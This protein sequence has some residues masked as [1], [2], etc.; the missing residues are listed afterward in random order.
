MEDKKV[1]DIPERDATR[2][3]DFLNNVRTAQEIVETVK[4]N[5]NKEIEMKIAENIIEARKE[6][7]G[8]KYLSQIYKIKDMKSEIFA[9]I[10]GGL[11]DW[12]PQKPNEIEWEKVP[13]EIAPTIMMFR[14]S[15]NAVLLSSLNLTP[16]TM[17]SK[18]GLETSMPCGE[19]VTFCTTQNV[20][21]HFYGMDH[22]D[23]ARYIGFLVNLGVPRDI[24]EK[25]IYNL[26]DSFSDQARELAELEAKQQVIDALMGQ[27][28]SLNCPDDCPMVIDEIAIKDEPDIPPWIHRS[29]HD[30]IA[31]KVF[32]K[33]YMSLMEVQVRWS[34]C[35][36]IRC[37]RRQ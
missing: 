11:K 25:I 29:D 26:Q 1:K 17:T 6:S 5:R 9:D 36:T 35:I 34:G 27:A 16:S 10:V 20:I 14:A 4:K 23:A 2:V 18:A 3:L 12:M 28:Y 15:N 33:Y 32:G 37:K 13:K 22:G 31:E 19:K 21:R 8:F 7:H 24:A 30:E